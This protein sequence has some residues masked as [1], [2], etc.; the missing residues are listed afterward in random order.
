MKMN[1][2]HQKPMQKEKPDSHLSK[3]G[4]FLKKYGK[5]YTM[6]EKNDT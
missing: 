2:E 3:K 6:E 5:K 4:K 1:T